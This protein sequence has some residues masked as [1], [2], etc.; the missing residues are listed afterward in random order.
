M[1]FFK[2]LRPNGKEV[3]GDATTLPKFL[4]E[5]KYPEEE[6]I[7]GAGYSFVVGEHK[8]AV[9]RI[10]SLTCHKCLEKGQTQNEIQ[11][12]KYGV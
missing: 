2:Y 8:L 4:Y 9:I 5:L 7:E 3:A 1:V 6:K 10:E 12:T 11:P